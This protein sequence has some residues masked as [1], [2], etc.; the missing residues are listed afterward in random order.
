MTPDVHA[1]RKRWTEGVCLDPRK[2]V[3]ENFVDELEA[4][5]KLPREE[6]ERLFYNGTE[7]YAKEWREQY[8]HDPNARVTFYDDSFTHIFFVMHNSALRTELSSPLLYL[9]GLDLARRLG[10]ETY[11]D[12]GAGTGSGASFFARAGLETTVADISSRMLEF[13]RWRFERRGCRARYLDLKR[14]PL[15]TGA[16]DLI[17]CFHVL[18]HV[19][20]PVA[21]MRELRDALKPGGVLLVNGALRK[22]PARPMQPDHGGER[23][24]RKFRSVGLQV[25]WEPIQEMRQLSNTTPQA[26]RRVERSPLVNTAYFVFDTVVTSPRVRAALNRVVRPLGR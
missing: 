3:A 21:T 20:D 11:L 12:Y 15:P 24:R 18:Q 14:E 8:Q 16:F 2:S 7:E 9:Y 19:E 5:S 17:T 1:Y 26:Y 6:V 4:Y 13:T 10:A 22:D 23:T 25:W